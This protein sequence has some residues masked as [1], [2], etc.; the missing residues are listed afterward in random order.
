MRRRT[1]LCKL[2]LCWL[3]WGRWQWRGGRQREVRSLFAWGGIRSW[4]CSKVWRNQWVSTVN[5]AFFWCL[6]NCFKQ[7]FFM[8]FFL[9][10]SLNIDWRLWA[11][12]SLRF[13][14]CRRTQP[15][16]EEFG[17]RCLLNLEQWGW[18]PGCTQWR[19]RC[20]NKRPNGEV[21]FCYC[22]ENWGKFYL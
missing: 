20:L 8:A 16:A 2:K 6:C 21:C 3:M 14:C 5:W 1:H 17:L 11:K 19:F 18:R 9:H 22:R 13:W 7:R 4:C 12:V 10:C 15:Y